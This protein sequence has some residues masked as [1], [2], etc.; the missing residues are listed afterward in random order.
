MKDT[1]I[2]H[3]DWKVHPLFL[4]L[5]DKSPYHGF[6]KVVEYDNSGS[7]SILPRIDQ[8]QFYDKHVSQSIPAVIRKDLNDWEVKKDIMQQS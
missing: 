4:D 2:K 1:L 6:Y 7:S 8:H 3:G 5:Q